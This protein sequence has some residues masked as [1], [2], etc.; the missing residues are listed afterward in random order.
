MASY[1]VQMVI[2][3]TDQNPENFITNTWSCA[4]ITDSDANDFVTALITF[5]QAIRS[6][7]PNTL[8]VGGH[9]YKIYNMADPEPRVPV[10]EGAWSF[11]ASLGG[12][13]LPSETSLC[14]SFQGTRIS[15]LDQA[16][17]RGRIYLGPFTV[18]ATDDGRPSTTC[19]AAVKDAAQDLLDAGEATAGD[20][21]WAVY[22]E[23]NGGTVDVDNGW[24][25]NS[26]DTQRRRG[27]AYT[28]RSVFS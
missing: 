7:Y 22:S 1:R 5:Y 27:I 18:S 23:K 24:V 28:T 2:K 13:T 17:R 19:I 12:E 9:V 25:D 8:E 4:A 20:W 21:N 15:G 10:N 11:G 16:S 6:W 26:W 3:T 14:L